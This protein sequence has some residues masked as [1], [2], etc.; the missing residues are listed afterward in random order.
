MHISR[1]DADFV[2]SDAHKGS[3]A[4]HGKD[5]DGALDTILEAAAG[6]AQRICIALHPSQRRRVL[7]ECER[8]PPQ[9]DSNDPSQAH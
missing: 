8:R 5:N 7:G 2:L 6:H 9:Q 4:L 1:G 3:C